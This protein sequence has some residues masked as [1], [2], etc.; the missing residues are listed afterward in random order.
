MRKSSKDCR[1]DRASVNSR[2]QAELDA[3][4]KGTA[5]YEFQCTDASLYIYEPVSGSKVKEKTRVET[6]TPRRDTAC[7]YRK[8]MP[9]LSQ[10]LAV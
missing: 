9:D 1:A 2:I 4:I 3:A 10:T 5:G 7:R 8:D 6:R